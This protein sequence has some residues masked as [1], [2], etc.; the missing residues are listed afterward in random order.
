[1][2]FILIMLVIVVSVVL[3]ELQGPGSASTKTSM[4]DGRPWRDH[5]L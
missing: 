1:M 4:T 5:V 2:S 3:E